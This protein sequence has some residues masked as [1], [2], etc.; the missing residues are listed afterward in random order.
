MLIGL[1]IKTVLGIALISS[2]CSARTE[3]VTNTMGILEE[4]VI[5]EKEYPFPRYRAALFQV[6][7]DADLLSDP[8]EQRYCAEDGTGELPGGDPC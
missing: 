5:G 2:I 4:E 6:G 7:Y 8:V 3:T 1:P